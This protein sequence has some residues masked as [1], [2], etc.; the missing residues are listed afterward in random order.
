MTQTKNL[1]ARFRE[2]VR[3]TEMLTQRVEAIK[4]QALQIAM[5]L[6][7]NQ[8]EAREVLSHVHFLVEWRS[9]QEPE[10]T[11]VTLISRAD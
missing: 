5:M 6:P 11:I 3:G 1:D 7:E 9:R 4:S 2:N 8:K 10:A